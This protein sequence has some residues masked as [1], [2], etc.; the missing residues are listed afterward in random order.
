MRV[1]VDNVHKSVEDLYYRD[2]DVDK[3]V[4]N[5]VNSTSDQFGI[6]FETSGL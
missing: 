4:D 5:L 6:F 2:L 3:K 1:I